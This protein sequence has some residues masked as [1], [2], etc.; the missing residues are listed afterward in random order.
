[1]NIDEYN[2][3]IELTTDLL[4]TQPKNKEVYKQFIA[5]KSPDVEGELETVQE[6]EERGWTGFATD[7]ISPFLHDYLIKGFLCE[8]ARTL[9]TFGAMKQ[10]QDKFKRYVFVFGEN[11]SRKIRLPQ[12]AEMPL[13]RPLRALTAQGPRVTV[14]RSDVV[15]AGAVLSFTIKVLEGTAIN[16]ACLSEVLSYGQFIG[17]GQWRSG[18]YGRFTVLELEEV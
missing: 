6:I 18:S 13:E 2:V 15:S 7:D 8:S 11:G 17:L 9:K 10:L 14:T 5:T 12:I 3:K 16:K 4:G 1:M